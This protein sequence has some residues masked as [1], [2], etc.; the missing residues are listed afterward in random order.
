MRVLVWSADPGIRTDGT[1]GAAE[2]VRE[3]SAALSRA[4]HDVTTSFAGT[5]RWPRGLRTLGARV[6]AHV[7][8]PR[9]GF[10]LVWERFH[11]ASDAGRRG[12]V[13]WLEVNAPGDLERR[14]PAEARPREL[15]RA[16]RILGGA[17]RVLCVS[18]WLAG[19][20]TAVVGVPAERVAWLPNGVPAHPPGDREGTRRRLGLDGPALVFVGSLHRWQGASF[21]PRLLEALPEFRALLVG[22]GPDAVDPH[23]RLIRVGRVP[24]DAVPDLIAAADVGVAPYDP[25]GPPWY[26]PLKV[27]R[28][29]AEGLPVVATDVGDCGALGAVTLPD[30]DPER[31]AEAC[32]AALSSPRVPWRRTW[33]DVV[34]ASAR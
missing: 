19:W 1:T 30:R 10:D 32:R 25:A 26:C 5:S 11:P 33:D 8:F 28:Y 4:G 20:A 6:D 13:R 27:L 7:R 16:R 2:H 22:D 3:L 12:R 34:A 14:W 21:L 15:E 24:G 29:R 9:G 18:R 31:W 17:D 23:P